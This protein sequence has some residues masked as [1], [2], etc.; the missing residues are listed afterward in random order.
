[1]KQKN[2]AKCLGITQGAVS[3][4]FNRARL[5]LDVCDLSKDNFQDD[6]VWVLWRIFMRDF[7][8]PDFL[9]VEIESVIRGLFVNLL[10]VINWFYSIGE[11]CNY[12]LCTISL[13]KIRS[14]SIYRNIFQ[15]LNKNEERHVKS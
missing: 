3:S 5:K 7:E 14:M 11:L 13:T 9:E 15:T 12:I 8:L 6:I 2:I 4:A 10:P 1:M